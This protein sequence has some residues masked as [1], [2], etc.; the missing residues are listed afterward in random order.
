MKETGPLINPIIIAQVCKFSK[1][2]TTMGMH[3]NPGLIKA[4][5]ETQAREELEASASTVL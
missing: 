5:E 4:L 3:C 1:K 2:H